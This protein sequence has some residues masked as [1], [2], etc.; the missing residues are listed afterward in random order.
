[1]TRIIFYLV[2]KPK[3]SENGHEMLRPHGTPW[4]PF[5]NPVPRHDRSSSASGQFVAKGCVR[6]WRAFQAMASAGSY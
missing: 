1:V 4:P 5:S 2:A 3:F 6:A